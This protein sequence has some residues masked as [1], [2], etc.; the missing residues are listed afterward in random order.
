M[1]L[2][3]DSAKRTT[4]VQWPQAVDD[5]LQVLVAMAAAAGDLSPARSYSRRWSRGR[6]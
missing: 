2:L 4:S 5:R 1:E 3:E 6:R